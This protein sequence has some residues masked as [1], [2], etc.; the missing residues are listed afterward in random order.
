MTDL[1]Q[2]RKELRARRRDL[3]PH[4]QRHHSAAVARQL[5]AWLPFLKA[6]SV[7]VYY[8]EDGEVDLS[9]VVV[10]ARARGK[11]V[12][13]PVLHPFAGNRLWFSEWRESDRL[14][15]NRFSIPEPSHR[16]RK[17]V[18]GLALDM[19]LVPLVG[20]DNSCSRLGMGGGFYDRS[21]AFRQRNKSWR[22]PVLVGIAHELQRV[23]MLENNEWDVP[24]DAVITER[25]LY[26]CIM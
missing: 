16:V 4:E 13:L 3:P 12:Y 1:R 25:H 14:H 2:I 26:R 6:R 8:S 22:R 7:A 24:L 21:F 23:A 15:L 11:R 9:T 18:F 17:P 5:N 19:V 10:G 20:F